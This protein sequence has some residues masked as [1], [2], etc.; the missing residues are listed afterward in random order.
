MY[1]I[2]SQKDIGG[3]PASNSLCKGVL[4]EEYSSNVYELNRLIIDE[5]LPK[6]SA[7]FLVG[8]SLKQLKKYNLCIVS[9]SDLGMNHNGYI[10]QAC[11]FIFTGT[12]PSRTDKYVP[13]GKHS[14]HY[15]K[16][17]VEKYRVLRTSKNR[18][19]YFA[20]N[21]RMKKEWAGKLR[22]PPQP[23]PKNE[24]LRYKIG[25]SQERFIKIVETGEIVRESKIFNDKYGQHEKQ[26]KKMAQRPNKTIAVLDVETTGFNYITS[27][28]TEIAVVLLDGKT[29]EEM[30]S[31]D[32]LIDI[33]GK[34]PP[35]IVELTGITNETT[36]KYGMPKDMVATY[37]QEMLKDTIVVAHN[38]Q[39]DFQF[40]KEHFGIVPKYY[41]DTLAISRSL[42]PSEKTHKLGVICE[43]AG[44]SLE[45]A[46]RAVNDTRATAQLINLQLN[47]EGVAMKYMNVI[48]SYRGVK[49]K[50]DNTREVL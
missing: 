32:T 41:Y 20:C 4:G 30:G 22:Y 11:N 45:G 18:Y 28:V 5:G 35:E 50:P 37:L 31:F 3:K 44:I 42:Y 6:N 14:R 24:S 38:V 10:Y 48:D 25:D 49:Y 16:G 2:N 13:K 12:T 34:I 1:F 29:G 26:E 40:I 33:E 15:D 46:H 23:Y 19:I 7:S 36:S 9:F 8:S 27:E 39:F 17:A 43:R 21:R 47:K